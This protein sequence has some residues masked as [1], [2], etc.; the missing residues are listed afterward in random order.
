MLVFAIFG[1]IFGGLHCI[2]WNFI[3]PTAFE[4]YLWHASSLAITAIPLIVAPIDF[5]LENYK[6]YKGFLK[7]VR[8]TLNLI[9][10][11]LIYVPARL[12]LIGPA[13]ALLMKQPQNAFFA[14]NWNRYI[15]HLF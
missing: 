1:V 8:L 9:M 4:Q 11:I 3:Y 6:L 15:P 14:V 5:I 13:F 2:G 12:T 10:T 7:V